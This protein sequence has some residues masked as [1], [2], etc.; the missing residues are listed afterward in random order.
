MIATLVDN[1]SCA[2]KKSSG[3]NRG[4]DTVRSNPG[5]ALIDDAALLQ[6]ERNAIEDVVADIFLVCQNLM[7]RC[8][9]PGSTEIAHDAPLIK[10]LGNFA[11][12]LTFLDKHRI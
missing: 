12:R 6:L 8:T 3:E 7:D 9:S 10:R 5:V 11:L 4:E 2:L 1:K